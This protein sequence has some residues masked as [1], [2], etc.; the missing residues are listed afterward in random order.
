MPVDGLVE[1]LSDDEYMESER[2]CVEEAS[3][4]LSMVLPIMAMSILSSSTAVV[5]EKAKLYVQSM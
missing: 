1:R 2:A 5:S 3:H 4:T